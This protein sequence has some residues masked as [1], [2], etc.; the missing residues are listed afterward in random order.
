MDS[1]SKWHKRGWLLAV[2]GDGSM[3]NASCLMAVHSSEIVIISFRVV[4]YKM[5][6]RDSSTVSTPT[7]DPKGRSLNL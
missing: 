1:A 7:L 5:G 2:K 3:L 6:K 4:W